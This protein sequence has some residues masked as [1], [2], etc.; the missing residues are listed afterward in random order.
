MRW[1]EVVI[2][3]GVWNTSRQEAE[4]NNS[5]IVGWLVWRAAT[6]FGDSSLDTKISWI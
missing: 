5:L 4:F 1:K 2:L 6:S 3:G